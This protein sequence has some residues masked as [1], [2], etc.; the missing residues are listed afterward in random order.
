MK[1]PSLATFLRFRL[2]CVLLL[3]SLGAAPATAAQAQGPAPAAAPQS[4][5]SAQA[6]TTAT[7]KPIEEAYVLLLRRYAL[8]L[9]SAN[10]ANAAQDGMV[11]AL[12]DAGVASPAPGLSVPGNDP[13]QQWM[14]L[15]QRYLALAAAYGNVLPANDLAYAA[16]R[17][18]TE[19]V[20]AAHT[21]F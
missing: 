19:S 18:M 13:Q 15:R 8:P 21:N 11:A 20:D 17:G 1:S 7:L 16:I 10:L 6:A 2:L 3:G 4:G 12:K 9:D 14:A 5:S